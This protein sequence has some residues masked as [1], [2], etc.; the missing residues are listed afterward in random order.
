[1]KVLNR[2]LKEI[3]DAAKKNLAGFDIFRYTNEILQ[4]ANLDEGLRGEIE[5][6]HGKIMVF[7]ATD[8]GRSMTISFADGTVKGQ[9]GKREDFSLKFEA[10]ERTFLELLSGELDPDSAFFRRKISIRGS[11]AEA[12]RFKNILFAKIL[13]KGDEDMEKNKILPQAEIL[14]GSS[15]KNCLPKGKRKKKKEWKKPVLED[16]SG[17]IMAQPYIRF[18]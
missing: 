8:T 4:L 5:T 11:I 17:K 18:T 6:W 12:L 14:E 7:E 9:A 2:R 1:M 13:R 3:T 16:V 15:I 10:T